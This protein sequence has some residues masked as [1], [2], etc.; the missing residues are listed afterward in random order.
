MTIAKRS[1]QPPGS[2]RAFC[3]YPN[4]NDLP[5]DIAAAILSQV[6]RDPFPVVGNARNKRETIVGQIADMGAIPVAPKSTRHPR[7]QGAF[8]ERGG[9][10]EGALPSWQGAHH[11]CG[12]RGRRAPTH[13]GP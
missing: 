7:L 13:A 1:L 10:E 4:R 9:L 12:A 11:G 5:A 2:E 8:R 6:G 3:A